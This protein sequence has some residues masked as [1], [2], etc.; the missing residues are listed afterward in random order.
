[1]AERAALV[2]SRPAFF[3]RICVVKVFLLARLY[4]F[5]TT[6]SFFCYNDV[7]WWRIVFLGFAVGFLPSLIT[8][9]TVSTDWQRVWALC[10]WRR[11]SYFYRV[12]FSFTDFCRVLLASDGVYWV[13]LG[14]TG[15]YWV[16]KVF[17]GF[18]RVLKGFTGFYWVLLASKG[19]YR[20]VMVFI[21]FYWVILGYNWFYW[22]LLGPNV[23]NWVL[24]SF[25][26]FY[27]VLLLNV[28]ERSPWSRSC[29]PLIARKIFCLVINV[30]KRTLDATSRPST[31]SS[32]SFLFSIEKKSQDFFFFAINIWCIHSTS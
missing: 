16:L 22:V 27:W 23:L 10:Q 11:Q 17:T 30:I 13:F 14:F 1:M 20:F 21:G 2:T 18:Y 25:T 8:P 3:Q 26:E 6:S 19:F 29:V 15:V 5:I 9:E 24:L 31:L 12:L 4:F 7:R 32:F 28:F